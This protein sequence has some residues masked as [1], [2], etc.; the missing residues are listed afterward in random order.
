MIGLMRAALELKREEAL[1]ELI[2]SRD[3]DF[4]DHRVTHSAKTAN[5]LARF[6]LL[7]E[8]IA[9]SVELP[10]KGERRPASR[11]GGAPSGD[12]SLDL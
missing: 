11:K 10:D 12:Q 9:D 8:L 6:L 5:A 7:E 2:E 1:A 4:N 3:A